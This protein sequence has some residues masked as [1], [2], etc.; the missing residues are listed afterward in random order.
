MAKSGVTI[1]EMTGEHTAWTSDPDACWGAMFE[2][3]EEDSEL[4]ETGVLG[5]SNETGSNH[6]MREG[7]VLEDAQS[8]VLQMLKDLC[9][10]NVPDDSSPQQ[11]TDNAMD[12]LRNCIALQTALEELVGIA[13]GKKTEDFVHSCIQAMTVLLNLFLDKDMSITWR[14][15]SVI[16]AKTQG[17]GK[18]HVWTL[19]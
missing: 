15:A 8:T 17:H 16:I 7:C 14:K 1:N 11:S 3:S 4:D 9:H 6:S 5:D 18:T 13:R 19:Q 10:G 12:L 2:E